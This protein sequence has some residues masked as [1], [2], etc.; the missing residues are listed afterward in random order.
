M[1]DV[2]IVLVGSVCSFYFCAELLRL[3]LPP[4][5]PAGRASAT[6]ARTGRPLVIRLDRR[7]GSRRS[8]DGARRAAS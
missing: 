6:D 8:L 2:L 7:R 1:N 5:E 4:A 3:M